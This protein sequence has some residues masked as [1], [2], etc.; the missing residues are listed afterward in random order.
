MSFIAQSLVRILLLTDVH[1]SIHVRRALYISLE[2]L[3]YLKYLTW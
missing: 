2:E 3:N 1:M